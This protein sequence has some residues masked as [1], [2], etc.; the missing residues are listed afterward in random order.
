MLRIYLLSFEYL[1]VHF[2]V[3][4]WIYISTY[5]LLV[6]F[7]AMFLFFLYH[8]YFSVAFTISLL[9]W[10]SFSLLVLCC[11]YFMF[12][13]SVSIFCL[14]LFVLVDASGWVH[15]YWSLNSIPIHLKPT[16][17]EDSAG[18]GNKLL[19]ARAILRTQ[20]DHVLHNF[21]N[22][23]WNRPNRNPTLRVSTVKMI[24]IIYAT[25]TLIFIR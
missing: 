7:R 18:S 24:S 19:F 9:L 3:H 1:L 11:I 5:R 22:F 2:L 8:T 15:V 16:Y 14:P 20:H 21:F 23:P 10:F 13:F 4:V 12:R 6:L 17:I 25:G